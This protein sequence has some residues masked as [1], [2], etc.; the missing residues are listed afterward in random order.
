M[1]KGHKGVFHIYGEEK[2]FIGHLGK[3]NIS[4]LVILILFWGLILRQKPC[5]IAV[6]SRSVAASSQMQLAQFIGAQA[7]ANQVEISCNRVTKV[8]WYV[9][10]SR[11]E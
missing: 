8:F 10:A 7:W 11:M 1:S 9:V 5:W 4:S 2:K 6:F 3:V